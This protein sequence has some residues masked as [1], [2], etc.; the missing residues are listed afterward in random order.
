MGLVTWNKQD[1]SEPF[2]RAGGGGGDDDDD[3]GDD[4]QVSPFLQATNALERVGV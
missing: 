1:Q 2:Q 4:R 3:D